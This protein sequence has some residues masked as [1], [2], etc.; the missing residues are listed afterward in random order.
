MMGPP[1]LVVGTSLAI[2]NDAAL[3]IRGIIRGGAVE[4]TGIISSR[5]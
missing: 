2:R 4:G 5:L 3:L 1:R